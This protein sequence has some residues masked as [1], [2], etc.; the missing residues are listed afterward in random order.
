MPS[1]TSRYKIFYTDGTSLLWSDV[2]NQDPS[3]IP[4]GKRIGVHSIIQEAPYIGYREEI[5]DYHFA[6]S[7]RYDGWM[8]LGRDGLLEQ[9]ANNFDD[10]YCVMHWRAVAT[11]KSWELNQA[12][13]SDTDI[14][15]GG[16]GVK[17]KNTERRA[18]LGDKKYKNPSG[19]RSK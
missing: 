2:P 1:F 8:G 6:F 3:L 11:E 13:R 4:S 9:V 19:G 14:Q 7:K 15:G 18:W 16:G 5:Q 12:I 10:V 17:K